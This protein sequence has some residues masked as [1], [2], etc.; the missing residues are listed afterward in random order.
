MKSIEFD[1]SFIHLLLSGLFYCHLSPCR[2]FRQC[3]HRL[4]Q[5]KKN[6]ETENNESKLN[7]LK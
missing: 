3:L 5:T 2:E 1:Y 7:G 4:L 6:I